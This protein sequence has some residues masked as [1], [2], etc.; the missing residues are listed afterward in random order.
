MN[1][2]RTTYGL[3]VFVILLAT[4]VVSS[5]IP[6]K[7]K[8]PST[9]PIIP[10]NKVCVDTVCIIEDNALFT[11]NWDSLPQVL[12]W[13]QIMQMSPDSSII[14]IADTRQVLCTIDV[15]CYLD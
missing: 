6:C 7:S 9:T 10:S 4:L 8:L 11:E 13:K 3:M 1:K 5:F 12:F 14:N 2:N 15:K